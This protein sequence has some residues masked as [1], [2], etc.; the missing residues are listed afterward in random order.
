MRRRNLKMKY[1]GLD[2][3]RSNIPL[4]LPLPPETGK[5]F[6]HRRLDKTNSFLSF[7]AS[8]PGTSEV[9]DTTAKV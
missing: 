8:Y 6:F 4:P 7:P 3:L 9:Y 2:E 1:F 5:T